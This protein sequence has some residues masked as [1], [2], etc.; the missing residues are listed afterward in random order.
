MSLILKVFRKV[1]LVI[2]LAVFGYSITMIGNRMID[3]YH[4]DRLSK[5]T[6]PIYNESKIEQ[7]DLDGYG[8]REKS[9]SYDKESSLKSPHSEENWKIDG[10]HIFLHLCGL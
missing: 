6:A 9:T 7:D 1:L 8:I 10:S 4:N 3:K 5:I 2:L